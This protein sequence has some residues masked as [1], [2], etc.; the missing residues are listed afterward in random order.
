MRSS[1]DNVI[2]IAGFD[3]SGGAGVLADIKTF[4]QL[5]VYGFA[6]A[7]SI[8]YQNDLKFDGGLWLGFNEI[9]AQFQPLA[10]RWRF[11]YAKIGFVESADMLKSIIIM[12]KNHNPNIK[13]IW[14]P[15]METSSGVLIHESDFAEEIS[16][17]IGDLFLVTPNM[18]E[19]GIL[20]LIDLISK[21]NVLVT[22]GQIEENLATDV[23]YSAGETYRFDAVKLE[24]KEKHGSGC[25][26]SAAI[27]ANLSM[28]YSLQD[29]CIKAKEYTLQFLLS[30]DELLGFHHSIK[31]NEPIAD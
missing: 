5:G 25:V 8:T 20:G 3:P 31:I 18:E 7:T 27:T 23:L 17:K 13:I 22:G 15:I 29:A 2:S 9:V 16:Q 26:L 14:D 30:S 19:A 11:G 1:Q 12:L 28:G 10:D 4:E 24:N 6:I 21:T